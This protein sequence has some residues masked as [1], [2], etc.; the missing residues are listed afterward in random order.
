MGIGQIIK[1]LFAAYPNSQV[2]EQTVVVYLK[3]LQDIPLD[4]LQTIIDQCIAQ[5]KFL[6]T[7]AELRNMHHTLTT[8]LAQ[9]SAAEAWGAVQKQ[10]SSVG[11]WGVP[12]FE[13][14]LVGQVVEMIG[15]Q[16]LC[17]SE[18]TMADR[19]HFLRMY[20]QVEQRRQQGKKLLPAARRL[21]EKSG[22]KPQLTHIGQ[23]L[24]DIE[25]N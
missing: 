10:L 1:Q 12:Q 24:S 18:N 6:P 15:W 2:T 13:D 22:Y 20:Q 25:N 23:L 9:P 11:N 7:V 17:A 3:L 16:D 4:E 8:S 21:A 14:S 5:L 19:A